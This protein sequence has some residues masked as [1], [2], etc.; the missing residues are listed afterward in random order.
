MATGAYSP[1]TVAK[2]DVRLNGIVIEI[3]ADGRCRN[4]ERACLRCDER[5]PEP[6]P[7]A[8]P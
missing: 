5:E 1:F 3:A 8:A 2:H 4:L 7:A 6:E